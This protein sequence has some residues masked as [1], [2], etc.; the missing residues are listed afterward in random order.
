M[1]LDFPSHASRGHPRLDSESNL[2][3][4]KAISQISITFFE[5]PSIYMYA[6]Y[7]NFLIPLP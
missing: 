1:M 2:Q 5:A 6:I 3:E 7:R 4:P